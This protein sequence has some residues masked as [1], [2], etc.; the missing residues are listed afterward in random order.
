MSE[1]L[2]P[3]SAEERYCRSSPS[4]LCRLQ[5]LQSRVYL[6]SMNGRRFNGRAERTADLHRV[7]RRVSANSPRRERRGRAPKENGTHIACSSHL[8]VQRADI[9][10]PPAPRRAVRNAI[11]C[12]VHRY[13]ACL[14]LVVRG[15]RLGPL[16]HDAR[17]EA[18]Q[19]LRV[20]SDARTGERIHHGVARGFAAAPT[21]ATRRWWRRG[22]VVP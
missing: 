18:G 3:N 15:L 12:I 13:A 1:T 10:I 9:A 17:L 8:F 16:A 20:H 22:S 4:I 11:A 19:G 6:A 2:E 14:A 5:G 21:S 7:A